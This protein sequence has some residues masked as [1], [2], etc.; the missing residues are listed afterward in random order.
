MGLHRVKSG[1]GLLTIALGGE[2][3]VFWGGREGYMSLLNTDMKRGEKNIL[4]VFLYAARDYA[5]KKRIQRGNSLSNQ[6]P[7][8]PFQASIRFM[9]AKQSIGFFT[10]A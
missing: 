5:R 2:N 4:H 8:E 7:C 6:K 9:T 10:S 3:Y 1:I